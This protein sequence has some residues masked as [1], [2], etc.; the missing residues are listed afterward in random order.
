M[1]TDRLRYP[2]WALTF[3]HPVSYQDVPLLIYGDTTMA[4][5]LVLDMLGLLC[6]SE[7]FHPLTSTRDSDSS[8]LICRFMMVGGLS[9][10]SHESKQA[11]KLSR[12]FFEARHS[13]LP[14]NIP[15]C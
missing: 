13:I 11:L 9:N 2:G 10:F 12:H 14:L 6:D 1:A 8:R 5:C 3:G 7:I 15:H 4:E